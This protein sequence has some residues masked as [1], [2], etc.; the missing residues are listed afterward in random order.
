M[1]EARS[2]SWEASRGYRT[3]Q[4]PFILLRALAGER[5]G[6]PGNMAAAGGRL[7]E[8]RTGGGRVGGVGGR[9]GVPAHIRRALRAGSPSGWTGAGRTRSGEAEG[10]GLR[11]LAGRREGKPARLPAAGLTTGAWGTAGTQGGA[12]PAI[13]KRSWGR[14]MPLRRKVEGEEPKAGSAGCMGGAGEG[15]SVA[16][17]CW[18]GAEGTH[19]LADARRRSEGGPP[20]RNVSARPSASASC[21]AALGRA[22]G[23]Q[24]R[25]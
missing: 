3:G 23:R 11:R 19:P 21:R 8:Q 13:P 20:R 14:G 15:G 24:G 22:V 16:A 5:G 17:V 10:V 1:G 7:M 9:V 2:P 12:G 25:P 18:A 6:D 4:G